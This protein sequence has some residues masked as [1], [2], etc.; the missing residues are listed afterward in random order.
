MPTAAPALRR[1]GEPDALLKEATMSDPA[2]TESPSPETSGGDDR[3]LDFRPGM[4]MWWEITRST[5]DTS[6]ELFEATNWIEPRMPGPP[7]HVHPTAEESYEVI[8]GALE[9]F[10][11]GHWSA[12][13]AG[14]KATVAAGCRIRY[15]TRATSPRES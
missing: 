4:G 15:A 5:K 7:V 10:M 11:N 6:G 3:Q 12:V 9:V 13:H 1:G 8:D 14:E 2:Q